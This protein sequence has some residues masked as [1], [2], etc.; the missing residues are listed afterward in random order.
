MN[1]PNHIIQKGETD[2]KL[3]EVIQKSLL[4]AEL[5]TSKFF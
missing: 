1:Y 5:P 4:S 3:V 2:K